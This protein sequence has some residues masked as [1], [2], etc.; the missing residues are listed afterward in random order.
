MTNEHNRYLGLCLPYAFGK[1][2]PRNRHFFEKHLKTGCELCNK[3]LA[4]IYEA[5][6]LLPLTLPLKNAPS[7]LL[8][9]VMVA[10]RSGQSTNALPTQASQRGGPSRIEA[11]PTSK[12]QRGGSQGGKFRED[13][14]QRGAPLGG[15]SQGDRRRGQRVEERT[16]S[17]TPV[18]LRQSAPPRPW[19]G[20]AVAFVSVVI[21][22]ALGLY[23]NSLISRLDS[24]EQLLSSQQKQIV[25]LTNEVQA[26]EEL[27]NVLQAPRIDMVMM[28]GL[29]PNPAGY[30]KI[31]WDPAKKVAIFQVANLPLA[32]TDKDYQLWIIKNNIPVSAGVFTVQDEKERENYFKVLSLDVADKSEV[33]A[34]A[35]TLEP[36]G[37]LPQPSGAMYLIGNTATK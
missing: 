23:T 12:P 37:G 19:F 35:V 13:R 29:E 10:A 26:K 4:E 30:G 33:D 24:Q 36:K 28:N 15:K 22:V 5:M 31:I 25:A 6:S 32:P 14:P 16:P 18:T 34:F 7:N 21:L 17:V 3:E 27:L 1:L 20:Y 2:N 11:A 8:N 9:K